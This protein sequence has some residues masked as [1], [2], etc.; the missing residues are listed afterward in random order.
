M[1][2]VLYLSYD[3]LTAPLG[4]SQILPYLVGLSQHGYSFTVLSF[5]KPEA[6]AKRQNLIQQICD[7]ASIAWQP[8]KYTKN[9]PVVSTVFDLVVMKKTATRLIKNGNFSLSVLMK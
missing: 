1:I 2:K 5:E 9:P 4:Q 7:E 3:G 8:L 6:F